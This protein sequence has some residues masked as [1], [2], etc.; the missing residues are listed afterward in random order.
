MCSTLSSCRLY[1]WMRLTWQSKIVSGSTIWPGRR[2]EP[3]GETRLGLALGLAEGVAEAAVVGQRLQLAQLAQVGDPA[4]ADG[5]GDQRGPGPG[6]PAA[7]S[8]AA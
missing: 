5:L 4:V 8:A 7:A 6:W 3:V 1:S 2:L